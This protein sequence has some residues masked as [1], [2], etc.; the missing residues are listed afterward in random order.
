MLVLE[1][2][3][4]NNIFFVNMKDVEDFNK[5]K[6]PH[7]FGVIFRKFYFF[8]VTCSSNVTTVQWE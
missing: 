4:N 2:E 1:L 6:L 8:T 3:F 7:F 5:I